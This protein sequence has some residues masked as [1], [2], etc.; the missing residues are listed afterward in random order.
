MNHVSERGV[1][2]HTSARGLTPERANRILRSLKTPGAAGRMAERVYVLSRRKSADAAA[3]L[4]LS[5][6]LHEQRHVSLATWR[7]ALEAAAAHARNVRESVRR[8]TGGA[9]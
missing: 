5:Q 7:D 6:A 3:L 2:N 8:A 9:R 1:Q 4:A